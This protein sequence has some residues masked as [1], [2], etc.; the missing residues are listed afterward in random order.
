MG[1]FLNPGNQMFQESLNSRIYV[2][3]SG[4]IGPLNELVSTRDKYVCVSRPRRFGKTM[5]GDMLVAYYGRGCDSRE[6]FAGLVASGL[7]SFERHLNAYDV[8]HLNI[9]DFLSE[10]CDMREMLGRISRML[11]REIL[12]EHPDVCFL[13]EDVLTSVLADVYA[14]ARVSF[15]FIVDEWDCIFRVR[16]GDTEAQKAYLDWLRNLL[17]DKPYVALAYMTGILPIKKYGQHSALNMFAEV[18]MVNAWPFEEFTG[19]T[20]GEVDALC[21]RYGRPI[22]EMRRWYDGYSVEGESVYNPRS[23]VMAAPSGVFVNYWT[24]T[25]TFDALRV[26]I[27]MNMG[28]LREKV[29]RL[30]A[31]ESLMVDVTTFQNDMTTFVT[32]DDVLT[33]LVHLGYLTYDRESRTVRV[34]NLEVMEQY[35]SILRSDGWAEVA[36]ALSASDQ[37]LAAMKV[38]DEDTVAELVAAAHEDAASILRYND[39]NSL[40]CA[41]SLAFYTARRSHV[42]VREMPTGKGFADLVFLPR[43]GSDGPVMV[44][45]LKARGADADTAL[46]QIRERRYAHGVERLAG[47]VLLVG[48]TYDPVTKEHACRIERME[49]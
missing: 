36:R 12:R 26:Y 3:K 27:E 39:E 47:E 40:A 16:Q 8:I 2:D 48:V 20:E 18:S 31:G 13:E 10:S 17:K 46:S 7:P 35:A 24:Q 30:I 23:V 33:L 34:P 9:Q 38:G 29:V 25:E 28:G 42:M 5:T 22:E 43:S 45:E 49:A 21:E 14:A 44:V 32:A 15:V 11:C 1:R 37:L 6:Q 41:L 4:I 19:F